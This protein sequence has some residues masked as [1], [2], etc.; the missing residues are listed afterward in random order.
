MGRFGGAKVG[1]ITVKSMAD[2]DFGF[3]QPFLLVCFEDS[4]ELRVS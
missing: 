1:A 3:S 2:S 4:T